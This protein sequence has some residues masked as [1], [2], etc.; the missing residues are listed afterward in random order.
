MLLGACAGLKPAVPP[1]LATSTNALGWTIILRQSGGFVG[2][3]RT[4]QATSDGQLIAT[5]K[6]SGKRVIT[7][8]SAESASEIRRLSDDAISVQV[9]PQESNSADCFQYDLELASETRSVHVTVDDT[10]L[11]DS[12]VG[13][14]V[15]YLLRL[16]DAAL[17]KP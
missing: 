6:R 7:Q 10:N 12:G 3:D 16:G 9:V 17:T 2:V 1:V 15:T 5:N 4:V 14:L 8:L 13:P 11:A